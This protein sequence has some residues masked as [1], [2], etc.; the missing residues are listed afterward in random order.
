MCH[1]IFTCMPLF[2]GSLFEEKKHFDNA[3]NPTFINSSF[4]Y[5][6]KKH[7]TLY[8]APFIMPVTHANLFLHAILRQ[9]ILIDRHTDRWTMKGSVFYGTR[10]K[11]AFRFSLR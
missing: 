11:E 8:I 2:D 3:K 4:E 9:R 7:W 1:I 5:R 10:K 6:N